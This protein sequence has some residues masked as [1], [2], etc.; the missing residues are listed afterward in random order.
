MINKFEN[1]ILVLGD[2]HAELY[3]KELKKNFY[4]NI[5][6]KTVMGATTQGLLNPNSRTNALNK[7]KESL[8][9][10]G[11]ITSHCIILIGEVDCGFVIWYRK[12]KYKDSIENQLNRSLNN[13]FQLIE[14]NLLSYYSRQNIIICGVVP[15]TIKDNT[16]K[17]FL[18]G[19][20]AE[21]DA[22]LLQRTNLTKIY[23]EKL[24]YYSTQNGLNY[25]SIFEDVISKENGLVN[26]F[27]R[28]QN[29]YNHHLSPAK[30]ADIWWK[31]LKPIIQQKT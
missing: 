8:R 15:P 14:T 27:Y 31:K 5:V 21:V 9:D 1:Q 29:K 19:A 13:Y 20:R 25:I 10:F 22:S 23:N 6:L 24:L 28:H 2:S 30:C 11:N 17:K 7:F 26:D 16:D 3:F 12:K 18:N 4:P